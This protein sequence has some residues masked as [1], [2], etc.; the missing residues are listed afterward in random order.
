M[1]FL[2]L[3][4]HGS[5]LVEDSIRGMPS[6]G[7]DLSQF[8]Q[9]NMSLIGYSV[10]QP[11]ARPPPSSSRLRSLPR[12]YPLQPRLP[13]IAARAGVERFDIMLT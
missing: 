3:G 7:L 10:A 8:V 12:N 6:A 11:G 2:V 9:I 4:S 5:T 13:I 1:N